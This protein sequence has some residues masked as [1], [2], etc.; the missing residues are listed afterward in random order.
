MTGRDPLLRPKRRSAMAEFG[1]D[2][3]KR[4]ARTL[5][6]ALTLHDGPA[7]AAFTAIAAATLQVD[8]RAAMAGAA[9]L[10]LEPEEAEGVARH[11]LGGAG[12]PAPSFLAPLPDAGIWAAAASRAELKA[13]L[14]CAYEALGPRDQ[15]AF[16]RHIYSDRRAAA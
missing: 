3:H 10:S 16:R 11:C 1:Q 12:Y 5:G 6:Y 7:W 15:A 14:A 4:V 9:L 2:R 13:Y 8:E